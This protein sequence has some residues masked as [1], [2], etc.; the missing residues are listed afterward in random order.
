M[1]TGAATS[2]I[3]ATTTRLVGN[4]DHYW[5]QHALTSCYSLS[6]VNLYKIHSKVQTT[7]LTTTL[8][9]NA[10][11][12]TLQSNPYSKFT[13]LRIVL[14][15]IVHEK[16]SNLSPFQLYPPISTHCRFYIFS[17]VC[18]IVDL[19]IFYN[20]TP[21]YKYIGCWKLHAADHA[22]HPLSSSSF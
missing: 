10:N 4:Y 21:P 7:T 9:L 16:I 13:P 12:I 17:A 20:Y 1:S 6:I 22:Y 19:A 15:G 2:M 14:L 3:C 8:K 5:F 18:R 11:L